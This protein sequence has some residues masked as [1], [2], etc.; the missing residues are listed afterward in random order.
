MSSH[1]LNINSSI[2]VEF[3]TAD[4]GVEACSSIVAR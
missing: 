1:T 3:P 4:A 2:A